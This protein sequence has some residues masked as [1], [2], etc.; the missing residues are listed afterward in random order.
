MYH[1]IGQM[2]NMLG[3]LITTT[4]ERGHGT[5]HLRDWHEEIWMARKTVRRLPPRGGVDLASA[6]AECLTAR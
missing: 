6:R 1:S 4:A 5:R 3:E 2:D